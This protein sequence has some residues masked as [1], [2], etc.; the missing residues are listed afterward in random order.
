VSERPHTV[1]LS[2][3]SQDKEA[4]QRICEALRVGGIKD[5]ARAVGI[6]RNRSD[7]GSKSGSYLDKGG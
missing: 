4:A 2:Y 7:R 6:G 3:A 5:S 1:F